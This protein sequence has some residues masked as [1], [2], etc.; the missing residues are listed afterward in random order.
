[1]EKILITGISGGLA[2]LV[3]KELSSEYE[4]IGVDFRPY[5]GKW[6]YPGKFVQLDYTKRSFEDIFNNHRFSQVLHLGRISNPREN[7]YKR[8][9]LNVL[10]TSNILNLCLKYE[11]ETVFI[12]STYHIYGAHQFN[13]V[14][15]E[16]SHPLRAGQ[17]FPEIIDAIELDHLATTFLL[18]NKYIRTIV[19]RPCNV[20]GSTINNTITKFLRRK[21]T[22]Y[23]MGFD[24]MHQFVHEK[25]LTKAITIALKQKDIYGVFN[26]AGAGSI[27][28]LK[29]IRE[30]G[31]KPIPIPHYLAYPLLRRNTKIPAHLMDYLRYPVIISDKKFRNATNYSPSMG[32]LDTLRSI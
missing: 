1:M 4:I 12:I 18:E 28:L 19:F 3:A 22:P 11:V 2:R 24:P 16:E 31:G 15:I 30:C 7:F 9:N 17:I 14:N 29:A 20:V 21:Y 10:G 8:Y 26:I 25:D 5:K 6:D 13:S 27:P 23:L 32:I